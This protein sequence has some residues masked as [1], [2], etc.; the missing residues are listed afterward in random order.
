MAD[1]ST[2]RRDA[3]TRVRKIYEPCE[4]GRMF[5]S[6]RHETL[7]E[8]E[9]DEAVARAT[10]EAIVAAAH[11]G[12]GRA[13]FWPLHPLDAEPGDDVSQ[14]MFPFYF[15][16]AGTI[17]AL[18][19][20]QDA[21]AVARFDDYGACL[22]T[23]LA[24][25]R[26]WL[27]AA[28]MG[29]ELASY[30]MGDT[31]VLMMAYGAEP[32]PELASQLEKL[33]DGNLDH[34]ARELMWG[35]P[36][37][38]LAALFLHE[39]FRDARWAVAFRRIAEHLWSQLE[40]SDEFACHYWTQDLYGR[41]STYL[42]AVH[43]FVATAFV[44]IRGRH[45][46][47][48]DAWGRWQRVIATTVQRTATCDGALVNWRTQLFEKPGERPYL[49]QY[50]H[51]A[52]GFAICLAEFPG[53]ELDAVLLAAGETTWAAGPLAKGS[54]LCHGTGGNGYAFLKLYAR[55]GD[56]RWLERARAFAMHGIR[57]TQLALE[58]YGSYRFSL[59][60]G[61][62]GLA[63]YLW[64]CIRAVPAFPTLDRFWASR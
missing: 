57:Q 25:N 33:L 30:L 4:A 46:L 19:Y 54:N 13:G 55:T 47:S 1:F 16:A 10:I 24:R 62:P 22:T 43:G 53:A 58:H 28:G 35:S 50:C 34:P 49:T 6:S 31:P 17:W 60:T 2:G 9:W 20:L 39:R 40:W 29:N 45:L 56:A 7:F 8:L 63:I 48:T 38:M 36:G 44:L 52:P 3:P 64:D 11:D 41:R 42:D 26:Q 15:G 5:T 14:P 27:S 51:G 59:W 18:R 37:T 23:V 21:G 12:F 61:D 32:S